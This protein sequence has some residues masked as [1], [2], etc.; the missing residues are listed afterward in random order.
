MKLQQPEQGTFDF[1]AIVIDGTY[2]HNLVFVDDADEEN[3]AQAVAFILNQD[4]V[5]DFVGAY[6]LVPYRYLLELPRQ[7]G[8]GI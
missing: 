8:V 4:G 1:Y 7:M 3:N 6:V 2:K 5:Y